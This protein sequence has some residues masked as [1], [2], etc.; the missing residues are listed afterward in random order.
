MSELDDLDFTRPAKHE[1]YDP[2]VASTCFQAL[3]TPEDL[4]QG[5]AFFV[6]GQDSDRMYLLAE[7]EVTLLRGRKPLDIVKPGEIFGE[8]ATILH[9]PRSASALARVPCRALS[10]DTRQFQRALQQTPQF[11]LML[12]SIMVSRLRLRISMLGLTRSIPDWGGKEAGAL[13]DR[14]LLDEWVA[15]LPERPPQR[16]PAGQVITREGESGIFMYLVLQGRV[17]ISIQGTVVERVGPGGMFG[18]MALLDESPRVAT[19][20]AEAACLF[21]TINRNDFLSL[22]RSNP[23]FAVSLLRAVGERLRTMTSASN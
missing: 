12:M 5:K 17:A 22:V 11:A 21:L 13:F 14:K 16:C 23:A 8:L 19:A 6:E 3:G 18:E 15:A 2:A 10:L 7:G 9:Q 20:A 1:I 4:P